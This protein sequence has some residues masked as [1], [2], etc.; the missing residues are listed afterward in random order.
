MAFTD[1]IPINYTIMF[2]SNR[3]RSVFKHKKKLTMILF[4]RG[5][6]FSACRKIIFI[7]GV[8]PREQPR[9]HF[10]LIAG[11]LAIQDHQES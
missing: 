9:K 8:I 7:L 11:K 3:I 2:K 4:G 6:L 1:E 10:I 5:I